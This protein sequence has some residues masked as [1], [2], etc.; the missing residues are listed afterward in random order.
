MKKIS[1]ILIESTLFLAAIKLRTKSAGKGLKNYFYEE[2]TLSHISL[3]LYDLLPLSFKIGMRYQTFHEIFE[4]NF[5]GIRDVLFE[6]PLKENTTENKTFVEDSK[7]KKE[8]KVPVKK[9]TRTK[10][11]KVTNNEK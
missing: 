7:D 2:E 5:K 10:V 9:A 3:V 6:E 1:K 11:K 4:K 8:I